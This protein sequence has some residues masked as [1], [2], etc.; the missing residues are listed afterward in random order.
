MFDGLSIMKSFFAEFVHTEKGVTCS[1]SGFLD[2]Y[3]AEECSSAVNYAKSF[4]GNARYKGVFSSSISHKGCAI[5][6][7]G[8]MYFNPHSTGGRRSDESSICRKGTT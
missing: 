7:S 4:N 2:L 8:N 3:S 5:Y 6:D 1:D